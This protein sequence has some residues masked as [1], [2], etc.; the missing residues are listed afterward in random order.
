[1]IRARVGRAFSI[2]AEKQVPLVETPQNPKRA[3]G[4]I[5]TGGLGRNRTAD[6]RIFNPNETHTPCR[7]PMIFKTLSV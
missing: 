5:K 6:T 4:R 1:M 7:K 2:E 3:L